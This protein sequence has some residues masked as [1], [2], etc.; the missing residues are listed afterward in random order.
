M[1]SNK[2]ASL[3]LIMQGSTDN[4][5]NTNTNSL[6]YGSDHQI[7]FTN[8]I[9]VDGGLITNMLGVENNA[10]IKNISTE[11]ITVGH[12]IEIQKFSLIDK[13]SEIELKFITVERQIL[14]NIYPVGSIYISTNTT[15]P[16]KLLA[17]GTWEQIKDRFLYCTTSPNNTGGSNN[18]THTTGNCTLTISQIPSHSHSCSTNGNHNH[19]ISCGNSAGKGK[20]DDA[21]GSRSTAYTNSSGNHSHTIGNTGDGGAHNHGN[22]GSS[23]NMP[24]Y[25]TVCAWKRKT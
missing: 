3:Q 22:T 16:A 8:N 12:D 14:E 13:I 23:S 7:S 5:P 25:M 21:D 18:H 11:N 20:A 1:S 6:V 10:V 9:S 17:I 24:Q 2:I 19:S 15:M 4:A